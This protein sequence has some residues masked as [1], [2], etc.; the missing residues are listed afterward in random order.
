MCLKMVMRVVHG[1][2]YDRL[3]KDGNVRDRERRREESRGRVVE[4]VQSY[5]KTDP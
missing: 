3:T 4:I 1:S 2:G 5:K